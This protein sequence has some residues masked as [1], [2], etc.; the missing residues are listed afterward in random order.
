MH[1]VTV[2]MQFPS[3]QKKNSFCASTLCVVQLHVIE[4]GRSSPGSV[5][6]YQWG[7]GQVLCVLLLFLICMVQI[8]TNSDGYI[9]SACLPGIG[10]WSEMHAV[11]C[12]S[13]H[14][15]TSKF[16]VLTASPVN[17][18]L[19]LVAKRHILFCNGG[20]SKS[21]CSLPCISYASMT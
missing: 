2:C 9:S 11:G 13:F 18:G 16:Y 21:G 7:W 5:T 14:M 10:S 17:S 6:L 8:G 19:K 1:K 4:Y 20:Q 3:F 12:M 15:Y